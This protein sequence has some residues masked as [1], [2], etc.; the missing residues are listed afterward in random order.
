VW[1]QA[2]ADLGSGVQSTQQN[3]RSVIEKLDAVALA[4]SSVN[5]SVLSSDELM[6]SLSARLTDMQAVV[7]QTLVSRCITVQVVCTQVVLAYD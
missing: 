3:Q 2:V 7:N 1:L 5:D 6:T 4:C